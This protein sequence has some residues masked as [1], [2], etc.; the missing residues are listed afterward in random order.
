M[1]VLSGADLP[2]VSEDT[3]TPRILIV[4]DEELNRMPLVALLDAEGYEVLQA[5]NGREALEVISKHEIDLVLLDVVMPVLD[6]FDTC[7]S[8]RHELE[9]LTLPVVFITSL[10]DRESRI[11]GKAAG[12]DDFLIKPFDPEELRARVYNLLRVKAY[13][14]LRARQQEYLERELDRMRAQLIR[15]DR[16]ATLGTLAAGVGHELNNICSVLVA[17]T[18]FIREN[19]EKEE[20]AQMEDV[21]DLET[22]AGHLKTHAKQ[23]LNL[24]RPGPDHEKVLD[25]R[26]IV[27][28]TLAMLDL[29]GK[30]KYVQ[31]ETS[32]PD[33]DVPVTVNQTRIE[34][35]F[36]NLVG[37]AADAILGMEKRA[38]KIRVVVE[39]PDGEGRVP[40]RIEDEGPGMSPKQLE[41]IFEPYFTTKAREKGTGL[42]LPVVKNI[43]ESYGGA[44]NVESSPGRG[45]TFTFDLPAA[46]VS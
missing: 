42:G 8:I 38:R 4:D 39:P 36:I 30:T 35:V 28:G 45:T 17:V 29:A 13:H 23:L 6:G 19:T 12:A 24:G 43:I 1:N 46:S 11:R 37:N 41:R 21:E 33:C 18:E 3:S 9:M 10:D 14:D 32:L 44:L 27:K 31:V 5:S 40:C 25:L 7:R 26:E 2:A 15:A 34:Q 22:V 20:P 16:L